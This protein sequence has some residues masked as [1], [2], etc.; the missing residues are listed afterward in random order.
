MNMKINK[1]LA[2][3]VLLTTISCSVQ[4]EMNTDYYK[5][6]EP[7]FNVR[8]YDKLDTIP[9]Q[10]DNRI[11]TSSFIKLFTD[12]HDVDYAKPISLKLE[13]DKMYLSF[14]DIH[15]KEFVL[16]FYGKLHKKNFI[17]YT[18]YKTIN[19]PVLLI[20]KKMERYKIC[21][22][23]NNDLLIE[24]Y[25]VNEG[26]MLCFGAGNSYQNLYRFKVLE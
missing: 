7:N 19:F 23:E 17:F 5:P 25:N 11:F 24:K 20:S 2:F 3:L 8:F 21:I 12:K 26:M 16:Q 6:L 15:K 22:S 4:N 10:Y 14:S 9:N 18:N 1:I 13:Q